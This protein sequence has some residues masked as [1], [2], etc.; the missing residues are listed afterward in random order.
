MRAREKGA[1]WRPFPFLAALLASTLTLAAARGEEPLRNWFDD[2]YFQVRSGMASCPAPRGPYGT[3]AEMQRETHHRLERGTR[4]WLE[5]RCSRPSSY[6][7]DA[8][9]AAA[10]RSRFES[11]ALLRGASLW[12]TVQHRAVWVE[13]CVPRG[14]ASGTVEK[15]L[16]GVPDV[17]SLI[18]NVRRDPGAKPPYRTLAP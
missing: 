14:Y 7:Y 3:E 16:R 10:V 1:C 12:V 15:L 5:K 11:T 17:E 9:I 18:V 13:G 2:P 4:C 6:L 8:D